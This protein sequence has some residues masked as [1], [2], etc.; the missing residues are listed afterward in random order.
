MH[1]A[2]S[3]PRPAGQVHVYVCD[4]MYYVCW[5]TSRKQPPIASLI[6]DGTSK[7]MD[8]IVSF[9][10][11][12]SPQSRSRY[13]VVH[14]QLQFTNGRGLKLLQ[15]SRKFYHENCKFKH[16]TT[17]L[18]HYTALHTLCKDHAHYIPD[19]AHRLVKNK[20]RFKA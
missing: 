20:C 15:Q 13:K 6:E 2:H 10:R 1:G 9:F 12:G 16:F 7:L 5:R 18:C 19:R 8:A 17:F 14:V 3:I 4:V 11:R